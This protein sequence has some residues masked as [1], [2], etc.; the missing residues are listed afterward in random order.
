VP[1]RR[2][3]VN[4]VA[5]RGRDK[6]GSKPLEA[7][8][9]QEIARCPEGE[10]LKD[11]GS[12]RE[13]FIEGLFADKAWRQSIKAGIGKA[14]GADDSLAWLIEDDE[15]KTI[16]SAWQKGWGGGHAS[17]PESDT[18][19]WKFFKGYVNG[20]KLVMWVPKVEVVKPGP[21]AEYDLHGYEQ[22]PLKGPVE[23]GRFFNLFLAGA[24]FVVIHSKEDLGREGHDFY[25][26]FIEALSTSTPLGHSHYA[27]TR[28]GNPSS[29]AVYPP[30]PQ[31]YPYI[32][33]LLADHTARQ[34]PNSFFQ[35]EGWPLFLA[36]YVST[37]AAKLVRARG[38]PRNR[39]RSSRAPSPW[40]STGPARCGR[41][42]SSRTRATSPRPP[43]WDRP[44]PRSAPSSPPSP[45]R[46]ALRR[47]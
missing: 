36:P 26:A 27:G 17:C 47:A 40:R 38:R 30:S 6:V 34:D 4:R 13:A 1:S 16:T 21:P 20:N 3:D 11:D 37:N 12:N 9:R 14:V 2:S 31:T 28:G 10:K 35:L 25:E 18:E 22:F 41:P 19:W 43:R 7:P 29:G 8:T 42:R 44:S 39:R 32:V 45:R 33:A 24:H 15:R 46:A 5:G 23:L